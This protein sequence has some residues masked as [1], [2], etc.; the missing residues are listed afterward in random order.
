MDTEKLAQLLKQL[1]LIEKAHAE[2]MVRRDA[3]ES[4]AAKFT[5][6]TP[7][8]QAAAERFRVYSVAL[9]EHR[10]QLAQAIM[11]AYGKGLTTEGAIIWKDDSE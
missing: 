2:I 10:K 6:G 3:S 7:H 8:Q 9:K 11:D 5:L 1:E 4:N